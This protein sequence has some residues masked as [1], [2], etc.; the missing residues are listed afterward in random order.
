MPC[1]RVTEGKCITKKW[2][3][4]EMAVIF[5]A[6]SDGGYIRELVYH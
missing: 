4:E 5:E 3:L 1:L 2:G 6:P